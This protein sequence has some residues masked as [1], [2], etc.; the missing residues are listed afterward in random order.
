MYSILFVC[1]DNLCRSPTA[2]VVFRQKAIDKGLGDRIHVESAA[3]HDFNVGE[4]VD[5][6]AQ[7]HERDRQAIFEIDDPDAIGPDESYAVPTGDLYTLLLKWFS[8]LAQFGKSAGFNDHILDSLSAT[9]FQDPRD[10]LGWGEN[11]GQID[12][13]IDALEAVMNPL[14]EGNSFAQSD[15]DDLARVSKVKAVENNALAQVVLIR[16]NADDCYIL[17]I[18][19]R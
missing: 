5:I 19:E 7:K 15:R 2:E 1:A 12:I 11:D 13:P 6:R 8:F 3:T 9:L 14:S 4:P 18:K 16:R 17:G 10:R